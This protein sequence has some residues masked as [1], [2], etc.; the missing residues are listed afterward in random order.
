MLSRRTTVYDENRLRSDRKH[1]ARKRKNKSLELCMV[2]G[3]LLILL[4]G[5]V[6]V[7][8]AVTAIGG[9]LWMAVAYAVS[10]ALL[11]AGWMFMTRST[12][13]AAV[14]TKQRRLYG[15]S[16]AGGN[17]LNPQSG[18]AFIL[19]MVLLALL[20]MMLLQSQWLARSSHRLQ[21]GYLL[22]ARLRASATQALQAGLRRLANDP[23]LQVDSLEDE[24]AQD[25]EL[26]WPDGSAHVVRITDM[27]RFFDINNLY[28]E[29]ANRDLRPGGIILMDL[30]TEAGQ[31]T[32]VEIVEAIQD[33]ID[34]DR[35]G[36][37]EA[38]YYD[39]EKLGYLPPNGWLKSWGELLLVDGVQRETWKPLERYGR[40][41]R[42]EA[43]LLDM[44]AILPGRRRSPHPVNLNTASI[45]TLRGVLGPQLEGGAASVISL[46]SA[47][48]LNSYSLLAARI[49]N[50]LAFEAVRPYLSFRSEFFSVYVR[51][52]LEGRTLESAALARRDEQGAVHVLRW[53]M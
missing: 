2:V 41:R 39:Q 14:K 22:D 51:S 44:T 1:S 40:V 35:E 13:N 21:E 37:R 32:P 24:W 7:A 46:R 6:G 27:N 50:P 8:W 33:W 49:A 5:G 31:F 12:K 30:M 29:T 23:D 26:E 15:Q 34:P 9:L 16:A 20:T 36:Y 3:G 53:V 25:V 45:E 52:Y 17:T 10:G 48:P 28:L 43:G 47:G 4:A 42:Y 18:A 19:V 11:L 38:W